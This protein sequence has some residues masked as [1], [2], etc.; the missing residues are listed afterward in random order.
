MASPQAPSSRYL[1]TS[2]G[3]G[4]ISSW[5]G[6]ETTD[7][8]SIKL[9]KI[10]CTPR[11][12]E[13]A[14]KTHH[15]PHDTPRVAHDRVLD[16][17]LS[18]G[19]LRPHR[20]TWSSRILELRLQPSS[21]LLRSTTHPRKVGLYLV[22]ATRSTPKSRRAESARHLMC[23]RASSRHQVDCASFKSRSTCRVVLFMPVATRAPFWRRRDEDP[24]APVR[25]GRELVLDE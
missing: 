11:S 10:C 22:H 6:Q 23:W 21:I 25:D 16:I 20:P 1:D 15:Q 19:S 14:H 2:G 12:F 5:Y 17:A 7:V 13:H 8:S 4:S 18:E 9:E 3:V 24:G